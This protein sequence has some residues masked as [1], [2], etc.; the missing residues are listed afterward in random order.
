MADLGN[1]FDKLK[2]DLKGKAGEA[3]G[4]S[5]LEAEGKTE[6]AA[7]GLKGAAQDAGDTLKGVV[8]GVKD[9][10]TKKD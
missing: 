6:S 7:A 8:D 4:D 1:T 9:A 2:G 3:S 5:H 10:F